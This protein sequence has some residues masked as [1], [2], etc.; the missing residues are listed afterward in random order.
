LDER[1][2]NARQCRRGAVE[3]HPAF[4]DRVENRALKIAQRSISGDNGCQFNT[5]AHG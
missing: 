5:F 2:P 3:N 1:F 4:V